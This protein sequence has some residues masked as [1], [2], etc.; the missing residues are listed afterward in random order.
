VSGPRKSGH[1]SRLEG[2]PEALPDPIADAEPGGLLSHRLLFWRIAA[3]SLLLEASWNNRNQQGLG[4]LASIDPALRIIHADDQAAL[5]QA[6]LKALTFFNTNPASS[7]LV[8]GAALKLEEEA[9]R[10]L[11]D[12]RRRATILSAL[13]SA[14]AA[15]GDRLFWQSWLPVCCLM[16]CLAS[17]WLAKPW[18][19]LLIPLMYGALVWPVRLK[20]LKFGY[21]EG[22]GA[23]TAI[24]RG[25]VNDLVRALSGAS[26]A[27]LALLA[28]TVIAI[29]AAGLDG[30]L[31]KLL[32]AGTIVFALV[33]LYKLATFRRRP[34]A[35]TLLY[36]A[37]VAL[38]AAVA[39]TLLT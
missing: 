33:R 19:P 35:L 36:P 27:L 24:E 12:E 7:A 8:I 28:A 22:R 39:A 34:L 26:A 14:L 2:R 9:K 16:A 30:P 17:C 3:R 37:L 6:R 38:I 10:G 25:R 13:S 5:T 21:R 18:I 4:F 1:D 31:W 20:G 11:I 15:Q 23:Y 32:I 29:A